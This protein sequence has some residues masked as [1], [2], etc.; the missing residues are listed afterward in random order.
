MDIPA[1][2]VSIGDYAF[3][4]YK[5]VQ[6][7]VLH[8]EIRKIGEHAFYGAKSATIYTEAVTLGAEWL[9]RWNSSYRP[10]VWGCTLSEDKTFVVSI[11]ITET[12]FENG[13]ETNVLSAPQKAGCE[14]LGWS[15]SPD[16]NEVAYTASELINAK[17]GETVYAVWR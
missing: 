15:L 3:K 2:V 14:F 10:I 17:I 12:T 13:Y 6:S 4:G 7:I 11:K 16:S 1:S 5:N 8:G 9:D